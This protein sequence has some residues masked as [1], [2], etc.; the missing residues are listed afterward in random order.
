[1]SFY[2]YSTLSC[3]N[4]Y[5][6]YSKPT[7]KNALPMIEKRVLIK[8]GN[9]VIRKDFVTPYGVMTEVTDAEMEILEKDYCFNEHRKNGFI[10]VEK[11]EA[12]T[13]K[14]V[15]DMKEKDNSAQKVPSDFQKRE[16]EHGDAGI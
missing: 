7:D 4:V 11:K 2:V 16:L 1:M 15:K 8:G 9:A 5:A 14:V 12:P 10:K 6:R 3:D 13:K